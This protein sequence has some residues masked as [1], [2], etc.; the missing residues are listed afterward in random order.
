MQKTKTMLLIAASVLLVAVAG[1][2]ISQVVSAQNAGNTTNQT[3]QST[4]INGYG[5]PQQGTYP[6]GQQYGS[7]YGAP[8]GDRMGMGMCGRNW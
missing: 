8:N 2:A 6:N 3:P 4:S 1:I 5:Y 7:Q